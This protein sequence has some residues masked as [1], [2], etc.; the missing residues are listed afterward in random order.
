MFLFSLVSLLI[1]LCLERNSGHRSWIANVQELVDSEAKES[2]M[3]AQIV[4]IWS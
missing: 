1:T 4:G 2:A 3:K